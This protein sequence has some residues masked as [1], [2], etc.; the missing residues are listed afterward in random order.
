M[1]L[2]NLSLQCAQIIAAF[3]RSICVPSAAQELAADLCGVR[4]QCVVIAYQYHEKED[5]WAL[6]ALSLLR[7]ARLLRLYRLI[8]VIY[9]AKITQNTYT[10]CDICSLLLDTECSSLNLVEHVKAC[11]YDP[12]EVYKQ[13]VYCSILPQASVIANKL[14]QE[15]ILEERCAAP[16]GLCG[17][18]PGHRAA[19]VAAGGRAV[20][21]CH[22]VLCG[23][24]GQFPGLRLV[25]CRARRAL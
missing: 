19:G 7:I 11:F 22:P 9:P 6:L 10:L 24:D 25:L 18:P 15:F 2:W 21:G 12:F 5:R 8:K 16:D 1:L 4:L 17:Q 23:S 20:P 13:R 14:C 3:V